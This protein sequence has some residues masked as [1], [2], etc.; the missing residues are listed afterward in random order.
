MDVSHETNHLLFV[1]CPWQPS[2][3]NVDNV[4]ILDHSLDNTQD[5][6]ITYFHQKWIKWHWHL[7]RNTVFHIFN[8]CSLSLSTAT[9]LLVPYLHSFLMTEYFGI[10]SLE[11]TL[12]HRLWLPLKSFIPVEFLYK[13]H[14]PSFWS[15]GLLQCAAGSS[16]LWQE[17]SSFVLKYFLHTYWSSS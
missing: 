12:F 14:E 11:N 6:C 4:A 15:S 10:V 1:V 3:T 13:L 5:Y 17:A 2:V 9:A 7:I 16:T 8:C